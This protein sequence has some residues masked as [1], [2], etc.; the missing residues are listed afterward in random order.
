MCRRTV[1]GLRRITMLMVNRGG[2]HLTDNDGRDRKA[3]QQQCKNLTDC[4][5]QVKHPNV[6]RETTLNSEPAQWGKCTK[7]ICILSRTHQPCA[8]ML[9]LASC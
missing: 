1:M 6:T 4:S 2:V 5:W 9:I 8:T 7:A 3:R